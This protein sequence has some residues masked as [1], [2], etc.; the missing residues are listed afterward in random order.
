MTP[1]QYLSSVRNAAASLRLSDADHIKFASTANTFTVAYNDQPH[2]SDEDTFNATTRVWDALTTYNDVGD[3]WNND[4]Q[5]TG[6][7]DLYF[8]GDTVPGTRPTATVRKERNW[9]MAMPRNIMKTNVSLNPDITDSANWDET[10]L[11]KDRIRSKW[12]A[13]EFTYDNSLGN[14]FSIPFVGSIYRQSKR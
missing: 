4:Y 5:N 2:W 12:I 9:S 11:Y 7:R 1:T 8:K 14:V 6:D 10:L 13:T 3:L